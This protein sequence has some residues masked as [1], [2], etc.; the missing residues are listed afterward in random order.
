MRM[1]GQQDRAARHG[2]KGLDPFSDVTI[3]KVGEPPKVTIP[4]A[5]ELPQATIAKAGKPRNGR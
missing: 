1:A 4:K 5:G 2:E 3:T